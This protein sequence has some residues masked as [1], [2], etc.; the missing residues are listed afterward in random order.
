MICNIINLYVFF[1][2]RD[3]LLTFYFKADI[4]LWLPGALLGMMN[5]V[6]TALLFLLPETNNVELPQTIEEFNE[7]YEEKRT[8]RKNKN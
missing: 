8:N 6:V 4:G 3:I 5:V 1:G 2:I 7:M